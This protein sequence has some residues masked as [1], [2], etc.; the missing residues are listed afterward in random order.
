M[1]YQPDL[2]RMMVRQ[3]EALPN[4]EVRRGWSLTGLEP[5]DDRVALTFA[6]SENEEVTTSVEARYV[7]GA[8]GARSTVR[9]RLGIGQT[10]LGFAYDWLVVDVVP[11][12]ERVWKPYVVQVCDPARP[13][14]LGGSG[15]GRRRWEFMRLPHETIEELNT[16]E[17]AWGLLARWNVTPYN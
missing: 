13:T 17:T 5:Q 11:Q 14:T 3:L 9:E 4:V 15:P 12:T 6:A 16:P 10:D 1:F 2:E 8:D 7:I